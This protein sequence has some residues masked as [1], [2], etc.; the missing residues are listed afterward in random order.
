[1]K[2]TLFYKEWWF[3]AS[4]EP[5]ELKTYIEMNVYFDLK[6]FLRF[7]VSVPNYTYCCRNPFKALLRVL[8]HESVGMQKY[9]HLKEDLRQ[10]K[11]YEVGR[12]LWWQIGGLK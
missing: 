2:K 11:S 3:P 7:S 10:S 9:D 6:E 4:W 1:M 12:C 5:K 8:E